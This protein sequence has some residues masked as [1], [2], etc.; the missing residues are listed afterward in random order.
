[1]GVSPEHSIRGDMYL[2]LKHFHITCVVLSIAGFTLRGWW[3]ITGSPLLRARN[4]PASCPIIVDTCLLGSAIAL[5]WMA[6]QY[7]FVQGWLTAKIAR[8]AGSTSVSGM[9]ALKPGTAAPPRGWRV[10]GCAGHLR[11]H[12]VGGAHQKPLGFLGHLVT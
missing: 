5:A 11:L 1:M 2:A 7:P 3:S 12:R 8:P 4:L 6:G 10:A 9:L